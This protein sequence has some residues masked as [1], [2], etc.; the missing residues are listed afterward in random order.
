MDLAELS[1]FSPPIRVFLQGC[2]PEA[3]SCGLTSPAPLLVSP[4]GPSAFTEAVAH[5]QAQYE[6]KNKS[7]HKE[8]YTHVTCATDTSNIQFV[9]DA[10][11]DVI[12]AKN[13]RGCGLY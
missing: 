6:S 7:A 10:V 2:H 3:L 12:I 5:I 4:T 11:T 8:I 9:F 13:L 1:R